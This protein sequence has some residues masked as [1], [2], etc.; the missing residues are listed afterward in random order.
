MSDYKIYK[1]FPSPVFQY[2]IDKFTKINSE[3]E[4]YILNLKK[5][6]KKDKKDQMLEV[7]IHLFLIQKMIVL[8][9]NLLKLFKNFQ[10]KLSLMKWD[11]NM[12]LIKLKLQPCGL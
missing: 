11:G 5:K 9:K 2:K 8:Q 3:L 7:G 10:K 4:N 1:L 6:T 12:L